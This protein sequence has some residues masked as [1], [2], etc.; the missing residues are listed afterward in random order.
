MIVL[1]ST[2]MLSK[3]NSMQNYFSKHFLLM[4]VIYVAS[5]RGDPH[6]TTLDG[7][8]YTF[9]GWGEYTLLNIDTADTSFILQGRTQP[10]VNS[11]ATQFSAFA[12]GVPQTSVVEVCVFSKPIIRTVLTCIVKYTSAIIIQVAWLLIRY[13]AVSS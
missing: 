5:C 10:V 1:V 3:T 12:F 13:Q 6:V 7:R 9:N 2:E 4:H 8:V 11:T